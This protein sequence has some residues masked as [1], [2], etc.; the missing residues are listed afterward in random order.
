MPWVD[1]LI[2]IPEP[3]EFPDLGL[4]GGEPRPLALQL[5]VS[6]RHRTGRTPRW[7]GVVTLETRHD[8]DPAVILGACRLQVGVPCPLGLGEPRLEGIALGP[9]IRDLAQR[10]NGTTGREE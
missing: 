9:Q 3:F 4:Q 10:T 1:V 7:V 6:A 2:H 8:A 5:A